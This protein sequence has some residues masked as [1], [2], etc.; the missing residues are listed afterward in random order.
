MWKTKIVFVNS[1]K[2]SESKHKRGF[3]G[4]WWDIV[5]AIDF[6]SPNITLKSKV[7]FLVEDY[8][9]LFYICLKC[10]SLMMPK[11]A[12]IRLLVSYLFI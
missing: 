9:K 1:I 10:V 4:F 2:N 12:R 5:L 6:F 8:I 3:F 7:V 11:K